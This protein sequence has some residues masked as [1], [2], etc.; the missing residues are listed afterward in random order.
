[1]S[2]NIQ[3]DCGPSRFIARVTWALQYTEIDS[4]E[5]PGTPDCL[6]SPWI[7]TARPGI[8]RQQTILQNAMLLALR[9]MEGCTL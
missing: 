7:P 2:K 4:D 5:V 6:N 9:R 8:D 3:T 1:M